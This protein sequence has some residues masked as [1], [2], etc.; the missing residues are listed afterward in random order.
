MSTDNEV[1]LCVRKP[2]EI[3]NK[4]IAG[5]IIHSEYLFNY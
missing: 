5:S 2:I 1:Q 4:T 3:I